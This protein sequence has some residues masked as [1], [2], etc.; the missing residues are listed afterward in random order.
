MYYE[1]HMV[2]SFIN[3]LNL[4]AAV[5]QKNCYN[6]K[7]LYFLFQIQVHIQTSKNLHFIT[8]IIIYVNHKSV[9]HM[10]LFNLTPL[11]V[12]KY[13]KCNQIR[14]LLNIPKTRKELKL[15]DT[16]IQ[17]IYQ[18]RV[19]SINSICNTYVVMNLMSCMYLYQRLSSKLN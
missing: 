13:I 10:Y 3:L 2:A 14:R 4:C 19:E 7:L 6:K 16:Y 18:I 1:I 17:C 11:H 8:A 12:C 9:V 5:S 15:I